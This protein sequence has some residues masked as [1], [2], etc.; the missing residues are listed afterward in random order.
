MRDV[1]ILIYDG[2][3]ALD[4]VG[5][6][7][8]LHAA[9]LAASKPAYRVRMLSIDG[10]SVRAETGIVL[11]AH[12]A[13]SAVN[14]LHT[15]IVPGGAAARIEPPDLRLVQ[16]I[17][18]LAPKS[19]RVVSMCTGAFLVASAG[20]ARGKRLATHWKFAS[21]LAERFPDTEV[22]A[23]CLYLR[24]DTFF[25]SAGILASIDLTL[26]L[27]EADVGETVAMA[28]ARDLVIYLRRTGGQ[29]QFSEPL[30][31]RNRLAG[32]FAA[33]S[34]WVRENLDADLSVE[35][36]GGRVGLSARHLR[37]VLQAE[38]GVSPAQFVEDIRLDVARELLATGQSDIKQIAGAVGFSG[39]DIF[40]RAFRRRFLLS[41]SI[42]RERFRLNGS[43]DPGGAGSR[44]AS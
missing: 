24:D 17:A 23:D 25:S 38:V 40:R 41:P 42:Y 26:A 3:Q 1:G 27:I 44:R 13:V 2:V 10:S 35:A 4:A 18:R 19:E 28:V 34:D 16:E 21:D 43:S 33:L 8:A 5:P 11:G 36:L 20:L 12:G 32:R 31:G 29:A 15:L 22:D 6:F 37:R 30:R 9:S 39:D 14:R 7:E